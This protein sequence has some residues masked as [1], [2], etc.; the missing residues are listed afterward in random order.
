MEKNRISY[1]PTVKSDLKCL[2]RI[3][4]SF[5]FE[6]SCK[7]ME[8]HTKDQIQHECN[9]Y[10]RTNVVE[11]FDFENSCKNMQCHTKRWSLIEKVG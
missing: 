1:K 4:K 7:N 5:K 9:K 6:N 8:C 11:I 3:G 10:Y 2:L